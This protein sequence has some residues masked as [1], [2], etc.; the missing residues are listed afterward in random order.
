MLQDL[1]LGCES[2]SRQADLV[3]LSG[4]PPPPKKKKQ[5]HKQNKEKQKFPTARV[6]PRN[7]R[8]VKSTRYR[9]RQDS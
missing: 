4:P 1:S 3:P 9:L 2:H 6:E 7:P 8:N 5:K